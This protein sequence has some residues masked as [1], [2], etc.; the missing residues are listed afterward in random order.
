MHKWMFGVLLAAAVLVLVGDDTMRVWIFGHS[1]DL[2]K[3]EAVNR[4]GEHLLDS[5]PAVVFSSGHATLEGGRWLVRGEA[6]AP[7]DG[8]LLDGYRCAI[9]NE[10]GDVLSATYLRDRVPVAVPAP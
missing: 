6:S 9:D 8:P 2:T 4:C 10:T 7:E 5:G 3:Q 1:G